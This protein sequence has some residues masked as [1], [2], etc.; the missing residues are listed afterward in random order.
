MHKQQSGFT[1]IELVVVIVILGIL[2][3]VAV[4]QFIDLSGEAKAAAIKGVAGALSSGNS[5]NYASRTLNGTKG[6][7]IANCSDVAGTIAGGLPALYTITAAAVAV[8]ATISCTLTYTPATGAAITAS[9]P[10]TG[11]V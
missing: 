7:S 8:N 9:F 5:I 6:V 2:A 3:V 1:L 11:I 4:P 10:A